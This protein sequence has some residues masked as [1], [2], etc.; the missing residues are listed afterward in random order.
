M[1]VLWLFS[2][3]LFV[4]LG[5]MTILWCFYVYRRNAGLVDIGWAV[6]FILTLSV[7][8]LFGTAIFEKK[9]LLALMVIP[10]SLR[11]AWHLWDR[12]NISI[13]DLRYTEMRKRMGG[14]ETGIKFLG[15]F[16]LQGLLIAFISI[17]F[18]L[19]VSSGTEEIHYLGWA[20]FLFTLLSFA[21]E[22]IADFQLRSFKKKSFESRQGLRCGSMVEN[23]AP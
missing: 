23:P 8:L 11:L 14:D 15:L 10:W 18:Y 6:S 5:F 12:F 16:L 17:P 3:G 2:L 21:G 1:Q 9:L 22:A 20:G 13:E 7:A 19:I 4:T